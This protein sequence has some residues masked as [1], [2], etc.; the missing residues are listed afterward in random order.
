MRHR[1][2]R[3]PCEQGTDPN[4]KTHLLG[5]SLAHRGQRHPAGHLPAFPPTLS[6]SSVRKKHLLRRP[7]YSITPREPGHLSGAQ[8]GGSR[9]ERAE[10]GA[11]AP[12]RPGVLRSVRETDPHGDKERQTERQ[13]DR[14]RQRDRQ[15]KSPPQLP[16]RE[17]VKQR[18]KNY[19][20]TAPPPR[21]HKMSQHA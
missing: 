19:D 16:V 4:T 11:A 5:L 21:H 17:Q 18:H 1:S 6:A 8:L 13:R 10:A 3:G 7:L 9:P 12:G 15:E 20:V 14:D 2:C